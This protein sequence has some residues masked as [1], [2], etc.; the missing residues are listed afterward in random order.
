VIVAAAA[1]MSNCPPATAVKIVSKSARTHSTVR[2]RR[3]A[4]SSVRSTSKPTSSPPST[5]SNGG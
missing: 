3:E 2:P 1:T 4:I 5:V